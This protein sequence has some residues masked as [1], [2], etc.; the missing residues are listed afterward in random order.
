MVIKEISR[1]DTF[2]ASFS[3]SESSYPDGSTIIYSDGELD[4]MRQVRAKLTTDH[5]IESSR[6]GSVFLAVAT[7][8]C[9][10]RVD[11]TAE[12]IVKLLG[13]MEKLGCPDGIDDELWKP[14]AKHELHPYPPVG[15]D[16]RG[17]S[18]T[19]IRGGNRVSKEEERNHAHACIMQ[20]LSVHADPTTLRN[21]LS[22]I[23]DM[24]G[25]DDKQAKVGN[26]KTVQA[27]YQAIPQRPQIILI[28]G[29]S[30]I[31]RTI[32]NKSI[33]LAS[34]FIKQKVLGRIHF[35]SVDDALSRVPL[36]S[37]PVYC[38]GEGGGVKCY[39]EWVKERLGQLTKPDLSEGPEQSADNLADSLA[40][41][42]I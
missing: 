15:T 23:I 29:S 3:D 39:K 14:D 12:K 16:N 4:A 2:S 18:I 26:E 6:V 22:F 8:N 24:S 36:K 31:M 25:K 27:F 1:E 41:T 19:W 21:G 9:K 5:G 40:Q 7:I 28:A 20:Y 33:K 42:K 38:G 34:L 11:E 10:L 37:A 13:L 35:V 30:F 32:I 17:C